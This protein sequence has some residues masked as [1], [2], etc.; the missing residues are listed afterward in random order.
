M[1]SFL[2]VRTLCG[3]DNE[4]NNH[5]NTNVQLIYCFLQTYWLFGE[6]VLWVHIQ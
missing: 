3:I 1:L 5:K 2:T 4:M 6:L